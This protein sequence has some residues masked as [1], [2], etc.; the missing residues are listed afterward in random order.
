MKGI[1]NMFIRKS[2]VN[3]LEEKIEKLNTIL[4]KSNLAE[5]SYL[6]G[7]KKQILFKNLTAGIFKGIGIG[8]GF[9]IFTAVIVIILRKIVALNIPIIGDFIADI[10]EIVQQKI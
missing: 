9:S 1:V 6:I 2:K 7:S 10:V 4:V 3:R 5:L 8:I